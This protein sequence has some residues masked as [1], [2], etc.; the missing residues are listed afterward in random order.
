M[1]VITAWSGLV[2]I[3]CEFKAGPNGCS[4]SRCSNAALPPGSGGAIIEGRV[5]A[6]A[7][8]V[9]DPKPS[10]PATETGGGSVLKNGSGISG[11][12]T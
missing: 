6:G 10:A 8:G 2:A 5:G 12:R 3:G 11:T 7:F 9:A 1:F 4:A